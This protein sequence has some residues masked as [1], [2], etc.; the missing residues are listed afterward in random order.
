MVLDDGRG[1]IG[2][3]Q[4]GIGTGRGGVGDIRGGMSE[5]GVGDARWVYL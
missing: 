1:G 5:D 3:I 4:G 2:D